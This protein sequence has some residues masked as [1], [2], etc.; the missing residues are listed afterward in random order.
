MH[1]P[2]TSGSQSNTKGNQ[3]SNSRQELEAETVEEHYLLACVLAQ[4]LGYT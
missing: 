2:Y 4:S 3:G 1:L